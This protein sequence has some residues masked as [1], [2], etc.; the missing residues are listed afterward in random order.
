[1]KEQWL[2]HP[3]FVPA[4]H[5]F[6]STRLVPPAHNA[7]PFTMPRLRSPL[8]HSQSS[9]NDYKDTQG[10]HLPLLSVPAFGFFPSNPP[11]SCFR[12]ACKPSPQACL[13][14]PGS[15]S[16]ATKEA[17]FIFSS[18]R[19]INTERRRAYVFGAL[20]DG[21]DGCLFFP[22]AV[23]TYRSGGRRRGRAYGLQG[24][25][26][27]DSRLANLAYLEGRFPLLQEG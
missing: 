6:P 11:T 10:K 9:T 16:G 1:M 8:P 23:A 21:E 4:H 25:L 3:L 7:T 5:S 12:P 2:L 19:A 18:Y 24:G 20:L 14:F 27:L 22:S 26:S 15:L 13:S 17:Y